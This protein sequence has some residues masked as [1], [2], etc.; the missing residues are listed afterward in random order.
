VTVIVAV[1]T[2]TPV[3]RPLVLTVAT[4]V[5]LLDHVTVLLVAALG[6][7]VALSW[8]VLLVKRPALVLSR[9]TPVTGVVTVIADVAVK[10]PS[11][12]VT[13][14]VVVPTA[15]PVTRPEELT[16]ATVVALLDQL[17]AVLVA[18]AG[19]SAAA[20]CCVLPIA[21]L[22]L[23]GLRLTP[24]TVTVFTVTAQVAVKLPSAVF[25]V[26]VAVPTFMAFT[27]PADETVATVVSELVQETFV[28]VALVGVMVVV[29]VPE[30]PPTVRLMVEALKATPVTA[31]LTADTVTTQVAVLAPSAV[32]TVI[33]LVPTATGATT[34]LLLTVATDVLLLVHVTFVL[35]AFV[36]V[37]VAV[38]EPEAP[39][40]VRLMVEALKVTPVT[41]TLVL[42][43]VTV[44]VA[45]LD[46]SAVVTVIVAVPAATGET[47]PLD[48]TVATA[49]LLLVQLTFVLVALIGVTVAVKVPEAP[50]TARFMV[51][52][53][54]LTAVTATLVVD[55]VTVQV[56]VLPPSAVVTV[57]IEVPA[58]TP[59]TS[60]L[61][62]T[63]A[64]E[65]WLLDQVMP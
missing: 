32:V 36:G 44:Q 52:A 25:T 30:A 38:K 42:V 13:V 23:V 57:T 37:I 47:T 7:T 46:P 59:V 26:T 11:A 64:T 31:T 34:P 17:R 1:P 20:S 10:P 51:E 63:V 50:P 8:R 16:V 56:A 18:V 15:T 40:T 19:T 33:V 39:P 58:A 35:V 49:V 55:T 2:A 22:V 29:K 62:L 48:D 41:A 65:L 43:T 21:M 24:V 45:V 6:D 27:S 3:T 53:L 28:F 9:L 60:P 61:E 4:E 54:R 12:V 5:A 14:I